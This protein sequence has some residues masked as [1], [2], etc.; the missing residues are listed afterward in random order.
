MLLLFIFLSFFFFCSSLPLFFFIIIIISAFL[1]TWFFLNLFLN[2]FLFIYWTC[3]L[4]TGNSICHSWRRNTFMLHWIYRN[5]RR[6]NKNENK[7]ETLPIKKKKWIKNKT[8]LE[9]CY[10]PAVGLHAYLSLVRLPPILCLVRMLVRTFL[11]SFSFSQTHIS[12][13]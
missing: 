7:R 10:F 12:F 1:V 3:K 9:C 2:W 13:L 8:K 5:K 6:T 4:D 11:Q